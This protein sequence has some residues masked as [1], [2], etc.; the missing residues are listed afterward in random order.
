M[1]FV[2]VQCLQPRPRKYIAPTWSWASVHGPII[3]GGCGNLDDRRAPEYTGILSCETTLEND[4]L[5]TGKVV[6]GVLKVRGP[7]RQVRWMSDTTD[8]FDPSAENP[9]FIGVAFMD[10]TIARPER[11][12]VT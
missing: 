3:I 11:S 6:N 9:K 7:L 8:L 2:A 5:R 10:A 1:W 12:T 4:A